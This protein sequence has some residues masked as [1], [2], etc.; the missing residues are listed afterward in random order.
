M[1]YFPY[2]H[3]I[4]HDSRNWIGA[5]AHEDSAIYEPPLSDMRFRPSARWADVYFCPRT[6]SCIPAAERL[7]RPGFSAMVERDQ[8]GAV[9]LYRPETN[10]PK[11]A[12]A[13]TNSLPLFGVE[14]TGQP[15]SDVQRE[16]TVVGAGH[17]H[18]GFDRDGTILA[19]QCSDLR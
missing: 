18:S 6:D 11:R 17:I 13:H 7:E 15:V 3:P 9:V 14:Q 5:R 4:R 16:L 1:Q 19:R 2:P 12:I 8:G 10:G